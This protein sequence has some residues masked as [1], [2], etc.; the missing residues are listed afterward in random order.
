MTPIESEFSLN[1]HH[2]SANSENYIRFST[3][4]EYEKEQTKYSYF[5][6]EKVFGARKASFINRL[7]YWL[8]KCGRTIDGLS[9]KWIYN[10][11]HEW[12]EQLNCSQSTIKR[13]IKVLEEQRIVL[14]KK[15]NAKKYN[16][17]KWYSLDY[18]ILQSL[19]K[20]ANIE[21]K[22]TEKKWTNRLGQ[23]EPIINNNRNNYTNI[24][25]KED[26]KIHFYKEKLE[27][28]EKTVQKKDHL[29]KEEEDKVKTMVTVWNKVFTYSL[30]PIK[31][32]YNSKN[33][34]ELLKLL[35]EQ[36]SDDL[37]NWIA[38]AKTV[39]SS[40]FLMGEKASKKNF[41]AVFSWL[42]KIET[43]E[44]IIAGSYGVGD[45]ELDMNKTSDNI[46]AQEKE[47]VR[48]TSKKLTGYV[49][50]RVEEAKEQEEFAEYIKRGE[51]EYG[52]NYMAKNINYSWY[53]VL[54]QPDYKCLKNDLY[55]S[56]LL[57][58]HTGY[59]SLE[60][61]T[62]IAAKIKTLKG[63]Q[64]NSELFKILQAEKRKVQ[65]ICLDTKESV[66]ML[67]VEGMKE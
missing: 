4:P 26:Q 27:V 61:K 57:K 35:A 14:S 41:K 13:V 32:F 23:N 18:K 60:I 48:I 38:Y 55:E 17:T 21:I 65:N 31:A 34:R 66:N 22:S 59:S 58:K 49:R 9:G 11:T 39:N 25:S 56:Y 42:I 40:A 24:S 28:K 51:D 62:K 3:Y 64:G 33:G 1:N 52:I 50:D 44:K 45:R 54:H 8:E 30:S 19:L 7:N 2:I 46:E 43:V 47:L 53:S 5:E 20:S 29:T 36:F 6:L 67:F 10:P 15:V 12:A 37:N 16:Q 63:G